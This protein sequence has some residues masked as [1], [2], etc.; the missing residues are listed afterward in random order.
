[1]SFDF[2]GTYPSIEEN[3][4]IEYSLGDGRNVKIVFETNDDET[5][6][7]ETFDPESNNPIE[8]QKVGWQ[9][10]LDNFKK[11]H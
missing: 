11:V 3:K 7:T 4:L 1:M 2:G 5:K 9:A 10:I 6:I 8:M